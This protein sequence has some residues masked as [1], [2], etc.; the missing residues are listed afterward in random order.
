[1]IQFSVNIEGYLTTGR[2]NRIQECV[3]NLP[4][5]IFSHLMDYLVESIR[6]D[7]ENCIEV[8]Y[9]QLHIQEYC[10]LVNWKSSIDEAAS[11]ISQNHVLVVL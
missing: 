8:S 4:H 7:I 5:P 10:R 2:Y 3:Q 9:K 6:E 11:F 1:M